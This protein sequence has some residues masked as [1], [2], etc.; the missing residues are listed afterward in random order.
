MLS[1]IEEVFNPLTTHF[2][3]F[4]FQAEFAGLRAMLSLMRV[5]ERD[6]GMR[7]RNKDQE[8]EV[9][10]KLPWKS[11][12]ETSILWFTQSR[13]NNWTLLEETMEKNDYMSLL[14]VEHV[15]FLVWPVDV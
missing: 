11:K 12:Q 7:V 2:P 13:V 9:H 3:H 1:F 10:C 14:F 8:M 15:I 6:V 5:G 4:T